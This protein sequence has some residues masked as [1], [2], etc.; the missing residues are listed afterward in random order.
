MRS[1]LA[2]I[3]SKCELETLKQH[4][5]VEVISIVNVLIAELVWSRI[6]RATCFPVYLITGFGEH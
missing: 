1:D 3:L 6:S 5:D 4:V 2:A